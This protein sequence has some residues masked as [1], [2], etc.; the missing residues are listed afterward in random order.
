MFQ[1]SISN[2]KATGTGPSK[3]LA[4]KAAAENLLSLLGYGKPSDN[5]HQSIKPALKSQDKSQDGSK[6]A[7]RHFFVISSGEFVLRF[8][9]WEGEE[10]KYIKF[11]FYL[12]V[13]FIDATGK[14]D[15]NT[16]GG[17]SMGRQL[18]PG[19]YVISTD[20]H[21]GEYYFLPEQNLT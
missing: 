1:V 6:K 13:T 18:K 17:G 7:S 12:Q 16:G 4:K 15:N 20:L 2:L 11:L 9:G 8:S 14:P 3:K 21:C 19:I 10:S 5:H